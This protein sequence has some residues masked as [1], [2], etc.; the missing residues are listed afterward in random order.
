MLETENK[1]FARSRHSA[2][3]FEEGGLAGRVHLGPSAVPECHRTALKTC[4][5]SLTGVPEFLSL[6]LAIKALQVELVLSRLLGGW[7]GIKYLDRHL[8]K[9]LPKYATRQGTW[10]IA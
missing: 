1:T 7:Q 8:A 10:Q 5:V 9:Y 3:C 4:M 6:R 2:L